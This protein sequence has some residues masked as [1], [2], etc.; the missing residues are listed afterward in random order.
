MLFPPKPHSFVSLPLQSFHSSSLLLA[1][2]SRTNGEPTPE[3][4][5]VVLGQIREAQERFQ[6]EDD[7]TRELSDAYL[8]AEEK[9]ANVVGTPEEAQAR[10]DAARA[11]TDYDDMAAK[12]AETMQLITD[13]VNS[14]L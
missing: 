1:P 13:L 7:A 8:A 4:R 11:L 12:C 6:R 14:L 3:N 5:D 2:S 9:V 10:L